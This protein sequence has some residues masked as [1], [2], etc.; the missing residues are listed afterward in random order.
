MASN[1]SLPAL[2]PRSK[3]I[4]AAGQALLLWGAF[5]IAAVLLNGT[6][7]FLL[8]RDLHA[9]TASPVKDA[10]FNLVIYGGV[11]LVAPLVLTKGWETVRQTGFL[12]P[13]CLALLAMTLRTFLRPVAALAVVALAYLHWRFDLSELGFRSLGWRGNITAVLAI[14]L[15]YFFPRL[16]QPEAFA[17]DF[18]GALTAGLDRLFANPAST[19]ENLFYFGFLTERLST[20]LGRGWTPLLVG[21]LYMLHE[22]TNPEY[23]YEG[24]FFP[25][26]F[27]G[28]AIV[29]AIYLWRRN[30]VAVWLG[31]GLGRLLSRLI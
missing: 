16:S 1:P 25:T 9:W 11:F 5:I 4:S 10:A 24:M 15:L 6:L 30:V 14:A 19:T 7:P 27:V 2:E 21:L 28:V 22:M 20:R 26:V 3:S 29:A 31:D 12:L 8:G 18:P 17:L 13:L 23:W